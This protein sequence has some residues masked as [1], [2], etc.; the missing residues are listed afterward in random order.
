MAQITTFPK[1]I[2]FVFDEQ[3]KFIEAS[4]WDWT[5]VTDDAG[6]LVSEF[7]GAARVLTTDDAVLKQVLGDALVRATQAAHDNAAA[8]DEA[9]RQLGDMTKARDDL[10]LKIE[11]TEDARIRAAIAAATS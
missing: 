7:E 10:A 1:R 3:Q 6:K 2:L 11:Q 4:T 9:L 5:R 8:R